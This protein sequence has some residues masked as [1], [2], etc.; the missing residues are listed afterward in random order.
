MKLSS[1]MVHACD[2]IRYYVSRSVVKCC[3][4]CIKNTGFVHTL[5]ISAHAKNP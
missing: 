1:F 5:E 2:V 3:T 4:V